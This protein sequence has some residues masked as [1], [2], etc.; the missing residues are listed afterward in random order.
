MS[1]SRGVGLAACLLAASSSLAPAQQRAGASAV[2]SGSYKKEIHPPF[3]L[4]RQRVGPMEVSYLTGRNGSRRQRKRSILAL[5]LHESSIPTG[6]A[7]TAVNPTNPTMAGFAYFSAIIS[8]LARSLYC[9]P[10]RSLA[11]RWS[12]CLGRPSNVRRTC[13]IP[14]PASTLAR[15]PNCRSRW[16]RVCSL[17]GIRSAPAISWAT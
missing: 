4:P 12:T 11:R 9:F 14:R 10:A 3:R 15:R 13:T 2:L 16:R 6:A 8:G 7:G 17:T 5:L 1:P